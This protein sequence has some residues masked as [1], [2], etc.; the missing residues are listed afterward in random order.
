MKSWTSIVPDFEMIKLE[1]PLL[2][3]STLRE[4]TFDVSP[5]WG[6]LIGIAAA[7]AIIIIFLMSRVVRRRK[8]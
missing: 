1:D 6:M 8:A 5:W 7:V 3:C 4:L 2:S